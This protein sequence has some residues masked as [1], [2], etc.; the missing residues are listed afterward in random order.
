MDSETLRN[1]LLTS[2]W[3]GISP[4]NISYTG[5]NVGIG[6]NNPVYT[7]DVSGIVRAGSTVSSSIYL[8]NSE[9]K[10]RGDGTA[11]FSI[12]NQNSTFQIRNTGANFEPGTAGSNLVTVTTSGN[13][14]IGT[15]NPG[16]LFQV[17]A[18][19]INPTIP[20]VHIGDN[21]ND[22][23]GT[24]GMV[25]L[26][27][28]ATPG[29]TKAHLS[30]IRNGNTGVNFGFYNNTNTFGIWHNLGNTGATPT[31]SITTGNNV[32][33]GTAAPVT[34]L[35]VWTGTARSGTAPA[36][37]GAIYATADAGGVNNYPP[38]AEFR[39]S[40]QTQ[41]IAI[42]F[43]AIFATG[44]NANQPI[45]LY[46]RGASEIQIL[47]TGV[48]GSGFGNLLVDYPNAG[49]AGGCI[50]IRNSASGVGAFSSLVF[51]VD[52]ST[53]TTTTSVA[54]GS[55]T[56]GNGMLYCQQV[57]P[58]SAA[59][60]G[61]I[62]WNGSAEV[63]TLTILPTG[64]VGIGVTNPGSALSFG[65]PVVNKIITLY[66]ANPADPVS[67]ATDFYGF[68][69]NGGI[70]RYQAPTGAS[71]RF[72]CSTT[73]AATISSTG[74]NVPG[75]ITNPGRPLSLVGKNNGDVSVAGIMVFN[76]VGYNVGSMYNSSNGRWTASVAG[77]YQFT[78]S[79]L[80]RINSPYPNMR[81]FINGNDFGWGACHF[82][83]GNITAPN[84][85]QLSCSVI[86]SM[87]VNDFVQFYVASDGFYGSSTIHNTACC[88]FLG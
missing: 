58:S 49:S 11:H 45:Y 82:N 78:Y 37:Y 8:T 17:N 71:H 29:D 22:Y 7:L 16:A 48:G 60:M 39:H 77:Y 87:A 59:K 35:D 10:W 52:G 53:A 67:T 41:G 38:I 13:V 73:L 72:F 80:S 27:R 55:F 76:A 75:V 61:F 25:N 2:Q 42:N 28:N 3:Y 23:G 15:T 21:A 14:G 70:L 68:G 20:T 31:I 65:Q 85:L 46:S 44:S 1:E 43:N 83:V 62:Q 79:G 86:I 4:G 40:N 81:W 69:I 57:G 36:S 54:P 64:R 34:R 74:I 66:D 18:A 33:I 30:M 63:E 56:Q 32:G 19:V 5:G 24:Y 9:V 12:F 47:G 26:T 50:T 84:H 88:I 6:T 51:E